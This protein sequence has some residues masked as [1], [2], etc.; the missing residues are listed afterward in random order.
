MNTRQLRMYDLK[1]IIGQTITDKLTILSTAGA[2]S[3]WIFEHYQ[4]VMGVLLAAITV[5]STAALQC[6]KIIAIR[7]E[8]RRKE[9]EHQRKMQQ[10]DV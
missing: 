6:Y 5:V 10:D 1:R 7:N 2:G 4:A 9:E 8:E 3:Y